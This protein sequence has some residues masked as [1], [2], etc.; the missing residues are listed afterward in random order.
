MCTYNPQWRRLRGEKLGGENLDCS[1]GARTSVLCYEIAAWPSEPL[2]P[3]LRV[4]SLAVSMGGSV[5]YH[6]R[7]KDYIAH[8]W[9]DLLFPLPPG[10]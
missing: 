4:V 8:R 9:Q 2:A 1:I 10:D 7:D 5:R 6:S 3:V